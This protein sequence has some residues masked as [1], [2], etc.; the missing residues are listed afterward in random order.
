MKS[1]LIDSKACWN[2][3]EH[4]RPAGLEIWLKKNTIVLPWSQFLNAEGGNEKIHV[5]FST[6]DLVIEGNGLNA[7]LQNIA[8]QRVSVMRELSRAERFGSVSGAYIS[9]IS[10]GKVG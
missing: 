6:Y 1:N 4:D 7:L 3:M 5:E 8:A 10:V 9:S 2:G